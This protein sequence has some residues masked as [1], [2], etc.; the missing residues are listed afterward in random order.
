MDIIVHNHQAKVTQKLRRLVHYRVESALDRHRGHVDRVQV[1]LSDEG[2]H[3]G[4]HCRCRM[5]LHLQAG[6]NAIVED[7]CESHG[8]AV[9]KAASALE[10][11]VRR[12][13]EKKRSRKLRAA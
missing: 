13:I 4:A 12:Q 11:S 7:T 1:W 9:T 2:L 10:R 6:G 5:V 3:S 8:A